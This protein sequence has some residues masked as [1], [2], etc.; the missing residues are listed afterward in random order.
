VHHSR[1]L[2]LQVVERRRRGLTQ[3][4]IGGV[5]RTPRHRSQAKAVSAVIALEPV[6]PDKVIEDAVRGGAR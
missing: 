5:T 6:Q 2:D 4:Q 1:C 3:S